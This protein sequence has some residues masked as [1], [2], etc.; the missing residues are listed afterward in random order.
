MHFVGFHNNG[1]HQTNDRRIALARFIGIYR[2]AFIG[3]AGNL[4]FI[5]LLD[6]RHRL[7]HSLAG[8]AVVKLDRGLNLLRR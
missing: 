2:S 3:A 8:F 1:G 4:A 7:V 6:L 5:Q